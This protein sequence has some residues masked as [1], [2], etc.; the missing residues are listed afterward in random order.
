MKLYELRTRPKVAG[1]ANLIFGHPDQNKRP[2]L[3]EGPNIFLPDDPELDFHPLENGQ[4]ILIRLVAAGDGARQI[5]YW[6]GGT[7]E[8]PFLVRVDQVAFDAFKQSGEQGFFNALKPQIITRIEE[9]FKLTTKRQ[10]DIFAVPLPFS[11]QDFTRAANLFAMDSSANFSEAAFQPILG[12]RHILKGF[13][14]NARIF[15]TV[16][17]LGWGVVEAPDHSPLSLDGIHL[18]AQANCLIDSRNAD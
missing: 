5:T 17:P 14:S 10:G 1:T 2:P 16:H 3:R 8:N 6:F 13:Y 4:K 18:L 12:T 7:E 11:V 15:G 9:A